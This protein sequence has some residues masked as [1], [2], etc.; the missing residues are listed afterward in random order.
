MW[1]KSIKRHLLLVVLAMFLVGSV[2]PT[3]TLP[4]IAG[5]HGATE[6]QVADY[7]SAI[8]AR[9]NKWMCF[10]AAVATADAC[11]SFNAPLC[12]FGIMWL[13]DNCS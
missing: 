2:I 13:H 3:R 8:G 1:N 10:A 11:A 4:P 7:R 9:A 12:A 6:T 5:S